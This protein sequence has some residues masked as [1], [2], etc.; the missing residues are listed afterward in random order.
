MRLWQLKIA[1]IPAAIAKF[2]TEKGFPAVTRHTAATTVLVREE[3][4]V[5]EIVAAVIP[6]AGNKSHKRAQGAS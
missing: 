4:V 5:V 3:R 6:S 2:K 1:A